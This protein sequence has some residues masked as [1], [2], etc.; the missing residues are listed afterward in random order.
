MYFN[1]IG[2]EQNYAKAF[3]LYSK[4]ATKDYVYAQVKLGNIYLN[5]QGVEKDDQ[6]TI[7][8]YGRAANH[9]ENPNPQAMTM[10]GIAFLYGELGLE[11][12]YIDAYKWFTRA[13]KSIGDISS[14]YYYIGNMYED[15]LGFASNQ[16]KASKNYITAFS[17]GANRGI[18]AAIE[19]A[20]S[21]RE[22]ANV[23]LLSHTAILM[24]VDERANKESSGVHLTTALKNQL[25]L[26]AKTYVDTLNNAG[27]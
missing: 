2:L 19:I 15:G 6:M 4:A 3:E 21:N 14:A 10:L 1:G 17:L 20:K 23:Y 25:E 7:Y 26:D 9:S 16:Q 27:S 5:G 18:K 8:W 24:G 12:S 11:T 22:H 13:T